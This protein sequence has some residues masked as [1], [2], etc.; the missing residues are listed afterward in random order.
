MTLEVTIEMAEARCAFCASVITSSGSHAA[1]RGKYP[2]VQP[3]RM[4]IVRKDSPGTY[5]PTYVLDGDIG[6]V[7]LWQEAQA[8]GWTEI[9]VYDVKMIACLACQKKKVQL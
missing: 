8:Q 2:I 5:R 6:P 9:T 1:E 7:A 4:S 3:E